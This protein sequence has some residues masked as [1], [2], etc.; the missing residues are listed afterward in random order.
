[1]AYTVEEASQRMVDAID[2]GEIVIS[3]PVDFSRNAEDT[4]PHQRLVTFQLVAKYGGYYVKNNPMLRWLWAEQW[5]F[6][7]DSDRRLWSLLPTLHPPFQ[8]N[9]CAAI[10]EA[11]ERRERARAR[12][13]DAYRRE[14]SILAGFA[15]TIGEAIAA[16]SITACDWPTPEGGHMAV[17]KASREYTVASCNQSVVTAWKALGFRW[18]CTELCWKLHGPNA[19]M[20]HDTIANS[21]LE[22]SER[23]RAEEERARAEAERVRLETEAIEARNRRRDQLI[24]EGVA[25]DMPTADD[26]SWFLKHFDQ[27]IFEAIDNAVVS[28][29]ESDHLRTLMAR[30]PATSMARGRP[31][32]HKRMVVVYSKILECVAGLADEI[33][34]EFKAVGLDPVADA[35]NHKVKRDTKM[36]LPFGVVRLFVR[37]QP[38]RAVRGGNAA[39]P[40]GQTNDRAA[41]A[42]SVD[43]L[44]QRKKVND[45][46][47]SEG[48]NDPEGGGHVAVN[49]LKSLAIALN[50]V[51]DSMSD[52]EKVAARTWTM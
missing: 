27:S 26:E 39:H 15:K 51:W 14:Q 50:G 25:G 4:P 38:S 5:G 17:I 2:N 28:K 30:L 32:S 18:N 11:N 41:I 9:V 21:T 46:L 48:Y 7:Y 37:T 49:S 10:E 1:M 16:G 34:D 44:D 40:N 6:K 13:E 42:W 3:G 43:F 8:P 36:R 47:V 22:A 12:A 35:V 31:L 52:A 24:E 19:S 29:F 23:I 20:L 45:E 33:V